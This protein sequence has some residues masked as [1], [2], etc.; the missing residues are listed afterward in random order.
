M[1]TRNTFSTNPAGSTRRA[2]RYAAVCLILDPRAQLQ[3]EQQGMEQQQEQQLLP[4]L[5]QRSLEVSA[6]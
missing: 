2:L 6:G 4:C 5:A 1:K 3:A